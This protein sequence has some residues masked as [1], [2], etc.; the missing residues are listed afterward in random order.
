MSNHHGCS[1]SAL[2]RIDS[3][4]NTVDWSNPGSVQGYK[5][6]RCPTCGDYWGIRYQWDAGTG[7]DDRV[8]RFGPGVPTKRHY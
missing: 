3:E 5:V 2:E 6:M 8:C 1:Y 4:L 7:H